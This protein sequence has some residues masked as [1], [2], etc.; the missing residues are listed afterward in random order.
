VLRTRD[1]DRRGVVAATPA[2]EGSWRRE[3]FRA[4]RWERWEEPV[5]HS[6][7]KPVF[8]AMREVWAQ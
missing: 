4:W 8:G 1:G 7:L 2:L 3:Q 6:R 5:W